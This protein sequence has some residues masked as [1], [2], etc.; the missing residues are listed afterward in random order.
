MK[1]DSLRE[2]K[3]HARAYLYPFPQTNPDATESMDFAT[4]VIMFESHLASAWLEMEDNSDSFSKEVAGQYAEN[5][6]KYISEAREQVNRFFKDDTPEDREYN[7]RLQQ[8]EAE[9]ITEDPH[10]GLTPAD[11]T[12]SDKLEYPPI[13]LAQYLNQVCI[14]WQG[15]FQ[16]HTTSYEGTDIEPSTALPVK[17]KF[18]CQSN[19]VYNLFYWLKYSGYIDNTQDEIIRFIMDHV[20][21]KGKTPATYSTIR[22]ELT[23]NSLPDN[24]K[25]IPPTE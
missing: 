17:L 4:A 13:K 1:T 5:V 25:I 20:S 7:D 14:F 6:I 18:S 16:S 21:I 24:K 15:L 11:S 8:M 19:Q 22:A 9:G 3:L 23:R 2:M 10:S 12:S